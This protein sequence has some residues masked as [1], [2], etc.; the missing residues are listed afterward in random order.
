MPSASEQ[1]RTYR[2]FARGDE[3]LATWLASLPDEDVIEPELE[4]V[5]AHHHLWDTPARGRYLLPE[6]LTDLGAGHRVTATV[7][8]ECGAMYRRG[9]PPQEAP[10]GEIEFANGVAAMSASGRYGDCAVSAGI[11]GRVDLTAGAAVRGLLEQGIALSGG[12]L[13]GIRHG[14]AWDPSPV[15]S[16]GRKAGAGKGPSRFAPPHLAADPAFRAGLAQ[17]APLGLVF[18]CFA[19]HSQLDETL[20]LARAF[21]DTT[22]VINHVGV[23]LGVGP[24]QDRRREVFRDWR[25]GMAALA[26]LP[27]VHVKLGGL[28]MPLFGFFFQDGE[29]PPTSQVLARAWQD[30]IGFCVEAFGADRCMFESNFPPDRQSCGYRTLW[31]AFKR[32][33]AAASAAE[34]DALYRG[35]ATRVY[36]LN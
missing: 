32:I 5:D 19:F 18:D 22:F 21:P 9:G 26:G 29:L 36:R 2:M 13:R 20:D 34:K 28:G 3:D 27:R 11:V 7:Y 31:N 14:L 10:L 33:T 24:Y 35:T 15:I 16:A 30:Y 6:L 4:I 23:P 25:A 8:V 12:R 1:P 17:L